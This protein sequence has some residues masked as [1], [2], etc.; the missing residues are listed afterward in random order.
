[1]MTLKMR[2]ISGNDDAGEDTDHTVSISL[3]ICI[4]HLNKFIFGQYVV[5]SY[6]IDRRIGN[7][8]ELSF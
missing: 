4:S 6:D 1:M 5:C 3:G 2:R 7:I 8:K